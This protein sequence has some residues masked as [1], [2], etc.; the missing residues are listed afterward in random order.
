MVSVNAAAEAA[1]A[2]GIPELKTHDEDIHDLSFFADA[3]HDY[4]LPVVALALLLLGLS[5]VGIFF[6]PVFRRWKFE[7]QK[8]K[9]AG[10]SA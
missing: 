4:G 3:A 10:T 9:S 7:R 2:L 8:R 6:V 1:F 5:G